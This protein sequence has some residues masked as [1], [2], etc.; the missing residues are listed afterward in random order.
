MFTTETTR[1][2]TL[3]LGSWRL[4]LSRH[5]SQAICPLANL[6]WPACPDW[7]NHD[8]SPVTVLRVRPVTAGDVDKCEELQR[9]ILGGL[10][11]HACCGDSDARAMR[12]KLLSYWLRLLPPRYV[13]DERDAGKLYAAFTQHNDTIP[14]TLVKG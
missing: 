1:S 7:T 10:A 2:F 6:Y 14:V 4:T 13:V 3:N 9:D 8:T 11:G 5:K 12:E